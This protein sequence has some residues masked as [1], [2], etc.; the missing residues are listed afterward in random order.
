MDYSGLVPH[1]FR[2]Y[3]FDLDGTLIDSLEDL[4]L[5]VNWILGEFRF[6]S[7]D[8]ESVRL[9]VGNGAR[10]LLVRAFASAA[11]ADSRAV[12]ADGEIDAALIRYR[13]HYDAHC[14]E[15]T[16]LYP[17]IREW[18]DTLA[19]QGAK[20]AVLTNKPEG[21]TRT[22]LSA[23]GVADRFDVI[24][25]PETFGSLKPDPAG[26]RAIMAK[27]GA[28][29]DE[30]VMIGDSTVDVETARNAGVTACGITGGLGDDDALRA[31]KP[32][33]LIERTIA[34]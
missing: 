28:R 25:G 5:S 29:V 9:G 34:E 14:T 8:E 7:I 13:A 6:S 32:D 10:N 11:L 12:P 23:L 26:L 15:H 33:I 31:S 4:A 18:L 17:G 30:T 24:A 3:V 1:R 2:L 16:R 21:A 19:A 27:C 20:L 22:L